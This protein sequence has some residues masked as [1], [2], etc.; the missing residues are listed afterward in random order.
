M[1]SITVPSLPN[2]DQP[3]YSK[4]ALI[5]QALTGLTTFVRK[6]TNQQSLNPTVLVNDVEL[7]LPL[8]VNAVYEMEGY[9]RYS[10]GNTEGMYC[11]FLAPAGSTLD[12]VDD[13]LDTGGLNYNGDIDRSVQ[14]LA[15]APSLGGGIAVVQS[16][17]PI[18]LLRTGATAG[19]LQYQFGN[20]STGTITNPATVWVGSYIRLTRLS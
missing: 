6:V 15:S 14:T 16:S 5:T 1:P 9:I 20:V 10:R 19:V 8:A 18:G 4:W 11:K 13:V 12:W 7:I 17:F 3:D 2:T